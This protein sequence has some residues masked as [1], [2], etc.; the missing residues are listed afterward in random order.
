LL[1]IQLLLFNIIEITIRRGQS[2]WL[3]IKYLFDNYQRLYVEQLK[4]KKL[5]HYYSN[6][7]QRMI[8]DHSNSINKS[9]LNMSK[10][11]FYHWFVG[12]TDGD[13]SFTIYG[14]RVNEKKIKWTLFFKIAQSS[15]NLRAL[16]Y[17]KKR[18]GHGSVRLESKKSMADFRIRNKD[19]INKVL[20]PIFDEYPLLTSKYFEYMKFKKAYEILTNVH[21]SN[22]EKNRLLLMIKDSNKPENYIS[23]IWNEVN[24]KIGNALDAKK[25]MSKYWLVGFTEAEGSF[26]LVQ[27]DPARLVHGFE[28]TQKLDL[29]VLECISKLLGISVMKKNNYNTVVTTNSRSIKNIIDYF[30]NTMKGMKALEFRIWARSFLKNKGDFEKL[31]EVSKLIRNIRL[32]R[33]DNNCRIINDI[34]NY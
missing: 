19:T 20:F 26:Y 33:L 14:Q 13:G 18:L 16:Y 5:V 9:K 12:F 3:Q 27:K 32:I 28:I 34:I 30:E 7:N 8:H 10:E 23:P 29:I 25:I 24:N 4:I 31:N 2:A 11:E 21:L 17:I 6:R 1:F 15:Y 22:E